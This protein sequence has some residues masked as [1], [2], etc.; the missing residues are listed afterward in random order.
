MMMNGELMQEALSGK[1][2]SFLGEVCEQARPI[3]VAR[4]RY[5]VDSIYL[6]AL[7]RHPDAEGARAGAAVSRCVPRQPP[8][9]ARPVLGAAEFQRVRLDPLNPTGLT[10]AAR[11]AMWRRGCRVSRLAGGA[12]PCPRQRGCFAR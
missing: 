6:A 9:P 2:G 10:R 12:I 5:M 8:G 11:R 1:P 4:E 3:A 7:S